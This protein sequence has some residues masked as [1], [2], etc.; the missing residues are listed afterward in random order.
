MAAR[1]TSRLR[2][3]NLIQKYFSHHAPRQSARPH[4]VPEYAVYFQWFPADSE[5]QEFPGIAFAVVDYCQVQEI[6]SYFSFD[7]DLD[8]FR[9]MPHAVAQQVFE[10][11]SEQGTV[12]RNLRV[13]GGI[14][15]IQRNFAV[16]CQGTVVEL[17]DQFTEQRSGGESFFS[18][19]CAPYSSLL[20][21]F[22]SSIRERS[23]SH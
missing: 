6:F 10:K 23:F 2:W 9:I 7:T 15:L 21:R 4:V 22:R 19:G 17:S 5:P 18:G 11:P 16:F 3:D 8:R 13:F 20:V 12:D 14:C 1:H